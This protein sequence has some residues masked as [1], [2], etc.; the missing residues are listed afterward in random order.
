MPTREYTEFV[1]G[2]NRQCEQSEAR[3]LLE[4]SR[5]V[6]GSWKSAWRGVD[7]TSLWAE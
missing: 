6:D 4:W 3:I 1:S 2:V 5:H 7:V